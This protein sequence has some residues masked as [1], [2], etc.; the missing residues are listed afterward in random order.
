MPSNYIAQGT[1]NRL[2]AQLIVPGSPVLNVIPS[3]MG[4]N[5][6]QVTFEENFDD[7]IETATGAVTSPAPYVMTSV[8]VNIL[9]TQGLASSWIAQAQN[10]SDIGNVSIFPDTNVFPEID[11]VNTVI[12]GIDPGAF[13]GMDPI[14]KV[15]LRGIFYI[16][17]SLWTL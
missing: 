3:F 8:V 11:L 16:N 15:T 2:R 5:M 17:N 14:V 12:K 7:Q 4:K 9:R 10:V 1:L 6:L 13:D